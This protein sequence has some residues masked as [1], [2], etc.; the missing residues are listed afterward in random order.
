MAALYKQ[1]TTERA[2]ALVENVIVP[3][4]E[5]GVKLDLKVVRSTEPI[6]GNIQMLANPFGPLEQACLK[7]YIR[8]SA[9]LDSPPLPDLYEVKLD[10]MATLGMVLA[11]IEIIGGAAYRQA[12]HI[13]QVAGKVPWSVC[14]RSE[15]DALN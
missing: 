2:G 10:G 8:P 5:R 14:P 13:K 12:W 6:Q 11:G 7:A 3:M 9:P 1:R 4:Y 15:L